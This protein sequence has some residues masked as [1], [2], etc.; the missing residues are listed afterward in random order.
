M[1]IIICGA[2]LSGRAIAEKLSEIGNEVTV[3]DSSKRLV[4][5]LGNKLDV[6]GIVGHGAHPDVL[7][8]AGAA[9]AEMLIA[10][11]PSDE[12]NMMACQVAHSLFEVPKRIARVRDKSYLNPS[13]EDLFTSSNLPVNIIISPE[14]E[15]ADSVFRRFELPGAFEN[16]PFCDNQLRFLGIKIDKDCPIIDTQIGSLTELF[17]DLNTV[18]TGLFRENNIITPKLNDKLKEND[19]AYLVCPS[20]LAE[21]TLSIFGK[22]PEM[23]R[24]IVLVGGGSI[25]REVAKL[26]VSKIDNI[27]LK[28]IEMNE[29]NAEELSEKFE[30]NIIILGSGMDKDILNE[31]EIS[32]ADILIS[33]TNSDETNFIS[34][35]F[36]KSDGCDRV[37]A[38]LNNRDFQGLIRSVDIGDYLDPKAIT[39][40]SI[41]R[42]VRR[43]HIR[44]IYT[45]T[46]GSA[47]IIEGEVSS[48][49]EL[50]GPTIE[51]LHLENGL[52]IGGILRDQKIIMPRGE[53]KIKEGDY[54]TIFAVPEKI[55]DVEQLFRV[56]SS[57]Y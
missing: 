51:E 1:K 42:H 47:E 30:K 9:D 53:T 23:A 15:V 57:Y 16:V 2:G 52:R 36:A 4:E 54:V 11:T 5:K 24:R 17:P 14:K 32:N 48:S 21:R 20:D 39:V 46:D 13:Y 8:D 44:N 27:S 26:I 33:L 7:G 50:V 43:G 38:L 41:L 37:L 35:A 56:S 3:I 34:A 18:I 31:A 40:S 49:S 28:I 45:L 25:G 6:R 29:K 10:V 19:L 22:K 55:H 12:I